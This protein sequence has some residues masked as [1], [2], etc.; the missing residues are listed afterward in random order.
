M[1][2]FSPPCMR[3]L[4][5]PPDPRNDRH[6]HT[7]TERSVS[8]AVSRR[9]PA[10]CDRSPAVREPLQ[11]LAFGRGQSPDLKP[12]LNADRLPVGI[13]RTGYLAVLDHVRMTRVEGDRHQVRA[14]VARRPA[15]ALR[16]LSRHGLRNNLWDQ[17]SVA[18]EVGS[19]PAT[20]ARH[21]ATGNT[22]CHRSARRMIPAQALGLK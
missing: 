21:N 14:L 4:D 8:R 9:L 10:M 5:P 7:V 6:G 22:F 17:S 15:R 11:P 13:Q 12:R 18:F 20:S 2:C 1:S 16:P 3:S 19:E